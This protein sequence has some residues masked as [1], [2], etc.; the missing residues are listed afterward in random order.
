MKAGRDWARTG[1]VVGCMVFCTGADANRLKTCLVVVR[2][3]M[4][5]GQPT[6]AMRWGIWV[7]GASGIGGAR[8]L[9]REFGCGE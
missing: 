5:R 8:Y 6:R 3:G 4:K 1:R 2:S 9:V 7:G